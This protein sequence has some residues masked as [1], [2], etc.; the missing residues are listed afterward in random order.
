MARACIVDYLFENAQQQPTRP[1]ILSKTAGTFCPLSWGDLHQQTQRVATG[2]LALGVAQNDRVCILAQSRLEWV[3]ADLAIVCAGAATVPIYSSNTPQECHHIAADSGARF[4]FTEDAAQTHKF[5]QQR[6]HLP[7]V[8][9]I[10]QIQDE[11]PQG[12]PWVVAY[13]SFA[14][15]EPQHAELRQRRTALGKD[16]VLTIIYTSGTTGKPKG[17]VTTHD[18]MLCIAEAIKDIEIVRMDDV[19]LLFLPL[20]HVFAKVLE[21]AWLCTGH[22]LAFA[23]SPHTLKEDMRDT[24]PTL[25]CGVPRIFE[26]FYAAVLAGGQ[27]GSPLRRHLFTRALQVCEHMGDLELRK[28]KPTLAQRLDHA[29]AKALVFRKIH[30]KLSETF[31]GRMRLL[32]SGGAPLSSKIGFF[33]RDAGHEI[34]EGWGLTE[35]SA[36]T[37]INRVGKNRIGS[38]GKPLPGMQVRVAP[39][40][41]LLVKGRAVMNGYW[42][43]EAATREA[44]RDGWF[45]SGDVGA[46]DGEGCVHILDRKKDLIVTAGG[47]NVAPQ[48]IENL[49]KTAKLISQVVVHGD[50]RKFC[51]ALITLDSEALKDFAQ[52][53]SLGSDSYAALTR[54][55]EVRKAVEQAIEDCNRQLAKYETIKKFAILEHDFS[56]ESGELTPSLKIKRKLINQRYS[57]VFD[58]FYDERY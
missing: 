25:M 39:D 50:K 12:D 33:F 41:E 30:Q 28:I 17:V 45:Y 31:G 46:M 10:I 27:S 36:A 29:L 52:Q 34:L 26:K 18:N 2:L 22:I 5:R 14:Q 56:Q 35:T 42:H 7:L 51:T 54:R 38:V 37:C 40:G 16:S 55:P 19:Q 49:L 6:A 44:V 13:S 20:A 58:G 43:S 11:V 23:Q 48:N 8:E 15:L 53:N 9:K 24:R 1:A 4:V 47:K 3:V 57:H 32:V 21:I